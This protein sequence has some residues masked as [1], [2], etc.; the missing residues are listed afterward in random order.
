MLTQRSIRRCLG[1]CSRSTLRVPKP[2]GGIACLRR[3]R[4]VYRARD[5]AAW[6]IHFGF[7]SLGSNCQTVNRLGYHRR[8]PIDMKDFARIG[9]QSRLAQLNQELEEIHRMFPGLRTDRKPGRPARNATAPAVLRSA[10]DGKP[11]AKRARNRKPMTAAQKKAVGDRM[12][13]YWA[14]R[15]KEKK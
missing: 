11:A 3:P 2:T 6:I 14:A 1:D 15:R 4:I 10:S 13:K 9:A 8:M 12:R 5:P 7:V